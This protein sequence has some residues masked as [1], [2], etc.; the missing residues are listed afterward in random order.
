MTRCAGSWPMTVAPSL[1]AIAACA[2]KRA[3]TSTSTSGWSA[4]RMAVAHVPR[5]PAPYTITLPP[6]TGGCRVTEC[7]L[8]ANGSANTASSSGTSSGT[9]KSCVSWAGISCAY[10]PLASRDVPVWMPGA[11]G[12]TPKLQH[13]LRSP[14]SH[15]GQIGS[16]PRGRHDSHGFSTTRSPTSRPSASG[17]SAT[18]SATTSCPSTCGSEK[19]P[20]IGLSGVAT[21][22][23]SM[24]TCLASEP[25]MPVSRGRVTTQSGRRNSGS[26]RSTRRIGV[27]ANP[28][29]RWLSSSGSGC[30]SGAT[31]YSRP[32]IHSP[33]PPLIPS[34]ST[35]PPPISGTTVNCSGG[36]EAL[37]PFGQLLVVDRDAVGVG[38]ELEP[39]VLVVGIRPPVGGEPVVSLH[40]WSHRRGGCLDIGRPDLQIRA[41]LRRDATGHERVRERVAGEV[42]VGAALQG[43]IGPATAQPRPRAVRLQLEAPRAVVVHDRHGR[44]FVSPG[45]IEFDREAHGPT[46]VAFD[47]DLV[48][49]RRHAAGPVVQTREHEPVEVESTP[50][51]RRDHDIS[52]VVRIL[53][54]NARNMG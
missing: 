1:R 10:P 17:P 48:A 43:R 21:F 44:A 13:K 15:A 42:D 29:S 19:K 9:L 49:R 24:N 39:A 53:I 41:D 36:S 38:A 27:S 26:G 18:T 4:R 46:L 51:V 35:V 5:A 34:Q 2:S 28:R 33:I 31:P 54:T 30:G 37:Q 14:A 40:E 11:I 8:T 23:Q 45:G 12:P 50:D 7:R 22:T 32:C 3:T 6:G 47:A 52:R 16:T 25:Q 20:F